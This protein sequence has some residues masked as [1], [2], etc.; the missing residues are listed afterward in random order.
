MSN[1]KIQQNS[2]AIDD[3]KAGVD[4]NKKDIA[5]GKAEH[6][7]ALGRVANSAESGIWENKEN[8]KTTGADIQVEANKLLIECVDA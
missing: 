4:A 5:S 2:A 3:N 1:E 7:A 8:L 6:I